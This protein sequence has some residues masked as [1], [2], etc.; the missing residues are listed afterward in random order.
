MEEGIKNR[1]IL[2]VSVIAVIFFLLSVNSCVGARSQKIAL[3]KERASSWDMEQRMSKFVQEKKAL[4]AQLT[5][6][7][8]ELGAEKAGHEITQK[9]LAQEEMINSSLKEELQK[10]TKLKVALEEDLKEALMAAKSAKPK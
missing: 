10:I 5:G 4:D 8:K 7:V 6:L 2:I 1:V 9:A 3:D